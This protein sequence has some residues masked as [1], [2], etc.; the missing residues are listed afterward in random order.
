MEEGGRCERWKDRQLCAVTEDREVAI[1][2][3]DWWLSAASNGTV[4]Q[5]SSR[6]LKVN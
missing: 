5:F 4:R 2:I 1:G 6:G 3:L